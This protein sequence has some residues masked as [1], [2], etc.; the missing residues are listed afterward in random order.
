MPDCNLSQEQIDAF[1]RGFAQLAPQIR[2]FI[3]ANKA[4]FEEWQRERREAASVS[5]VKQ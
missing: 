5:A 4:E 1:A 3:N 2:A